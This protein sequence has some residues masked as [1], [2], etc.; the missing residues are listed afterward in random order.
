MDWEYN[1]TLI[2]GGSYL[3]CD[4]YLKNI[5]LVIEYDGKQHYEETGFF[6]SLERQ[7]LLDR[8]KKLVLSERNIG[9]ARIRYNE[10]LTPDLVYKIIMEEA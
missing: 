7:Q 6:G 1:H 3:Y 10:D 9:I 5:Q 2:L 8:R 4:F